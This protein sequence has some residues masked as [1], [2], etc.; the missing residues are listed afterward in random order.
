MPFRSHDRGALAEQSPGTPISV[1]LALRL[2]NV[3]E[4][5]TLLVALHTPADWRVT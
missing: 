3:D 2:R 4:T 1:T 5:E